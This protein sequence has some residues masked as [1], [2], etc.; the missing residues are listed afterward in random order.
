MKQTNLKA[1]MSNNIKSRSLNNEQLSKLQALQN[2]KKP[3]NQRYLSIATA[4]LVFII[5]AVIFQQ[6]LQTGLSIEQKIGNEVA[7]NHIQLKPLEVKTSQL[8]IIRK[9]FTELDFLP[10]ASI[11]INPGTQA[12]IG[13]RYCSIQGITAAQLRIKDN[14]SG[15]IQSLYQTT[16]DP[17]LFKGIPKLKEGQPPISVHAKGITVD[18]WVEK[19]LL[20][21]LTNE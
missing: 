9:Y 12:L 3:A 10:I 17:N 15:R 14:S 8:D 4:V 21:A 11:V 19:G 5:S 16:Y 6:S 1:A 18:I 13:G 2:S 20:F 7:K